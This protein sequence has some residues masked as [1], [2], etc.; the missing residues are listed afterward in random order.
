MGKA[1]RQIQLL[2]TIS[3]EQWVEM[4]HKLRLHIKIRYQW[5]L[6]RLNLKPEDLAN[7]AI[8]DTLQG[9]RR[10][11]PN[12]QTGMIN[13]DVSLFAFLCGVVRSN[14]SHLWN[15]EKSNR[16]FEEVNLT[17]GHRSVMPQSLEMI[18]NARSDYYPALVK[19]GNIE[20]WIINKEKTERLC[21]LVAGDKELVGII[22]ELRKD[23][24]LKPSE[25]AENLGLSIE[26]VRAAQKRLR[27]KVQELREGLTNGRD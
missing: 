20:Q 3:E 1:A 8:L 4:W 6:E 2:E 12:N 27:R 16:S 14:A 24:T 5:L 26:K 23:P 13:E 7:Q 9:K 18:L 10:W 15:R 17:N 11:P 25:L 22:T 19:I 21:G